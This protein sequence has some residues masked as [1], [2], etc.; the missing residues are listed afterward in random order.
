MRIEAII[1]SESRWC[2]ATAPAP[3]A[4][5]CAAWQRHGGVPAQAIE[6]LE[7]LAPLDA[8]PET[9]AAALWYDLARRA[10]AAWQAAAAHQSEVMRRLVDG[11]QAAEKVF[12]LHADAPAHE[13][14]EG[15]RRLLLAMVRDLRVVF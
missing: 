15:L 14:T 1:S 2:G 12:S 13:H 7:I 4:A 10:P 5:A 3:L 8:D 6:M 11:Q 9:L